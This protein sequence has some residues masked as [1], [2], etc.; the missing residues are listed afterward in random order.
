MNEWAHT[1]ELRGREKGSNAGVNQGMK[2][3]EE[4]S[5]GEEMRARLRHKE[6]NA[7]GRE[8]Y[9]HQTRGDERTWRRGVAR[10]VT[11]DGE[12]NTSP[13]K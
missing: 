1:V 5:E 9:K 2:N 7:N 6:R 8:M 4:R 3:S 12:A 11:N 13:N 10:R